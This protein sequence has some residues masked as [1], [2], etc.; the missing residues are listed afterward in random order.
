M[1][2]EFIQSLKNNL[3]ENNGIKKSIIVRELSNAVNGGSEKQIARE[4]VELCKDK[5]I[6]KNLCI[7]FSSIGIYNAYQWKFSEKTSSF[8]HWDDRNKA[9][10][11]FSYKHEDMFLNMFIKNAG[12]RFPLKENLEYK[13]FE[14]DMEMTRELRVSDFFKEIEYYECDHHTLQQCIMR[15]LC[16]TFS[17]LGIETEMLENAWFPYI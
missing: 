9:S 17:E 6:C 1:T 14:K 10:Q 11:E 4:L 7:I 2:Q 12:F 16:V 13:C 5:K 15:V 8:P 3:F